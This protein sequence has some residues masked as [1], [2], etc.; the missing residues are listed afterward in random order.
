MGTLETPSFLGTKTEGS[1]FSNTNSNTLTTADQ[2]NDAN[3][4]ALIGSRTYNDTLNNTISRVAILEA[5][6]GSVHIITSD[7][8]VID[9]DGYN[10]IQCNPT[11][12]NLTVT[13]P[14]AA[15][16]TNRFLKVF[17]SHVGGK[18]TVDGEGAETINGS[19]TQILQ[20]QHDYIDTYCDGTEWFIL[21]SQQI[22]DTGWMN[23][24]D[25]QNRSLGCVPVTYDNLTG[26]PILGER[27]IEYSDA[28]RTTATGVEGVIQTDSGTVFVLK[29]VEGGGVFTNNFYLGCETSGAT[30]DVNEVSGSNK[31]TDNDLLHEFGK[32]IRDLETKIFISTDGTDATSFELI[33]DSVWATNQGWNPIQT[34]TD[35][36]NLQTGTQGFVY[37]NAAGARTN[38]TT[39]DY[40]Y[41]V[42]TRVRV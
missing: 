4:E 21:S 16:N 41:R 10:T 3:I 20:S 17:V 33:T 7:Y 8:T 9:D 2:V 28:G 6:A 12:G 22:I 1:T 27:V 36:F 13:F 34:D 19:L 5:A 26:T 42:I 37:I 15:D 18:V 32:N 11:G 25:I 38:L 39:A 24:S 29:N 31:N 35:S 30:M 40:Y 14:T 23:S